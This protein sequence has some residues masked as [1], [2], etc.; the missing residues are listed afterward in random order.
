VAARKKY[1]VEENLNMYEYRKLCQWVE[2]QRHLL[3]FCALTVLP[4][5]GTGE[6]ARLPARSA[7]LAGR[8]G[9]MH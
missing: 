7:Q 6:T 2:V 3:Q 4:P 1:N 8:W 9:Q 5:P